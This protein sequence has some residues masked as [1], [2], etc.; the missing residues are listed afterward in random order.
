[1]SLIANGVRLSTANPMRQ[2]FSPTANTANPAQWRQSGA[3]RNAWASAFLDTSAFPYAYTHPNA[4]RLAPSAGPSALHSNIEGEATF[5]GAGAMGVNGEAA[6]SGSGSIT[7]AD[8]ALV[9]YA[10]A[11]LS[12]SGSI[13][14]ADLEGLAE[15][16]SSL[17]GSG[18]LTGDAVAFLNAVAA[19]SGTGTLTGEAIATLAA[20]AALS[21]SG[22]LTDANLAGVIR[23]VAALAGTSTVTADNNAVAVL[24]SALSGSGALG[25]ADLEALANAVAALAGVGSLALTPYATGELSADIT[26]V[27]SSDA[28]T[29][30]QIA[31]AVWQYILDGSITDAES[32]S[33][34]M[35]KFLTKGFYLGTK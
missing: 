2:L 26:L 35:R 28:P 3:A 1:M 25:T 9:L 14:D 6:L 23:A 11:A 12:G 21:G 30:D 13:T 17:S 33:V 10:I 18:T 4:W 29:A 19:L 22:S 34:F 24:T 8:L 7:N 16:A 27:V 31:A 15:L 20:Q 5:A 32:A